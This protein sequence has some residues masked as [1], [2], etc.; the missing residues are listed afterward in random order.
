MHTCRASEATVMVMAVP[1]PKAAR[2]IWLRG[3]TCGKHT[4]V[5]A[6]TSPEGPPAAGGWKDL[7]LGYL[8]IVHGAGT[9]EGPRVALDTSSLQCHRGTGSH[10]GPAGGGAR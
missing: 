10:G 1:I 2:C 6:N 7:A 4:E 8:G 5:T 9:N 3:L